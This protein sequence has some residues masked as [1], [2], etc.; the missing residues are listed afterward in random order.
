MVMGPKRNLNFIHIRFAADTN[1][2]HSLASVESVFNKFNPDAPFEYTFVAEEHARKFRSQERSSK[3]TVLFTG[4]AVIITGMGL[5]DLPISSQ[6]E[7][8]RNFL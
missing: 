2:G 5:L 8:K 7:E 3:L 6:S 4:L 1:Y